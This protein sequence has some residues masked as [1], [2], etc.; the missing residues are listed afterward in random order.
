MSQM[1]AVNDE[2]DAK[3]LR[4]PA[5]FENAETLMIS[6]VKFLLE[7]RKKQNETNAAHEV[8]LSNNFTKTYNYAT[9]FSKF[10]NRETIESVR[11]LLTQKRFHNFELAAVANLLPDTAEEAKVLIPSLENARFP[12]EELQ[13]ILDEIQSKRSFQS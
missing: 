10:N 1:R 2:S 8:E 5:E 7:N 4:F 3:E 9:Q 12:E 11:N 13:Q 6:E